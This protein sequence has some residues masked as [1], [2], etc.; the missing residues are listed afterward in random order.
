MKWIINADRTM[1][2]P[3]TKH[4][5]K[6]KVYDDTMRIPT[7]SE[8]VMFPESNGRALSYIVEE[9][10]MYVNPWNEPENHYIVYIRENKET[11]R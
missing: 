4:K 8:K 6:Q 3:T 1:L 2:D 7:L 9:V 11:S 5:I 10:V